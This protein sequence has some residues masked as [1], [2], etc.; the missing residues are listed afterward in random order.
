MSRV[1]MTTPS[2]STA[3][4]KINCRKGDF[5]RISGTFPS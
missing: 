2:A 4:R 3:Q 1:A 5:I